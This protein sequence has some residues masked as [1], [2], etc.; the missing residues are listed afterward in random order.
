[1]SSR[2]RTVRRMHQRCVGEVHRAVGA[3]C[4]N[5]SRAG[6]SS[7]TMGSTVIASD[8]IHRHAAI[9]F[10]TGRTERRRRLWCPWSG[11][12]V[13]SDRT[14]LSCGSWRLVCGSSC[15][16]SLIAQ[17]SGSQADA[18]VSHDDDSG[19]RSSWNAPGSSS[20]ST[21]TAIRGRS[22]V[23]SSASTAIRRPASAAYAAVLSGV[24][25]DSDA[26]RLVAESQLPATLKALEATYPSHKR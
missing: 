2:S 21:W 9:T 24:A 5:P 17:Q 25:T 14:R 20:R 8:L 18:R 15:P 23:R 3:G 1:M 6:R 4:I 10:R 11:P 26:E 22:W 19:V 16:A 7:S 12:A 13:A